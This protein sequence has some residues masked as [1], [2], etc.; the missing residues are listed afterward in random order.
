MTRHGHLAF[1]GIQNSYSFG[2]FA[3]GRFVVGTASINLDDIPCEQVV[4]RSHPDNASNIFLGGSDVSTTVG[5]ILEPGDFSPY[6]PVENLRLIWVIA[7][8]A[9]QNLQ[10]FIVR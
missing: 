2:R 9:T 1:G 5:M 4:F 8:G 7:D 3:A 6:I 10:Y